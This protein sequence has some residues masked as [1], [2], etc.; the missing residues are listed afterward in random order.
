[1]L[2]LFKF[3]TK[4]CSLVIISRLQVTTG[5]L[6]PLLERAGSDDVFI[7]PHI[8]ILSED[9]LAYTK[10]ID[11]HWGAFSWRLHFRW[12][13][14]GPEVLEKKATNPAR[15]YPTPAMA[16]GL[17]AVRKSLFWRLGG[18]DKG[19]HVWGAENLELSWRAWQCGA[20]VEITPCSRVGHIFRQHSPHIYPGGIA[21]VLNTNL[22][23]AAVVW[24][25]EWAD[26]VFKFNPSMAGWK[27]KVDVADRVELR[28]KLKC[29]SF[30]WY[31]ENVWPENFFPAKDRWFGRVKNGKGACLGVPAGVSHQQGGSAEGIDCG[32]D[33]DMGKLLVFTPKGQI[34]ADESLCLD[35]GSDMLSW[36][37]CSDSARQIWVQNGVRLKD[38]TGLCLTSIEIN[39]GDGVGDP[40]KMRECVEESSQIWNFERVPWR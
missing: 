1:M 40:L 3:H 21:K 5:W 10:S 39:S 37:G 12:I 24:M 6:E 34:M 14:P 23:R 2:L 7:C 9:T 15:P 25:D 4:P 36:K 17:F 20:R 28:K 30:Q 13:V 38:E 22:A 8:D 35:R 29:K 27:D 16:G 26:F 33:L 19:M 31:L 11:A 32:S 18:Y